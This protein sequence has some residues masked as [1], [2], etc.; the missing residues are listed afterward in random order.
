M[1]QGYNQ[2]S[3]GFRKDRRMPFPTIFSKPGCPTNFFQVSIT[4]RKIIE[5][6]L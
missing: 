6:T 2:N 4:V 3:S 1:R 5:I